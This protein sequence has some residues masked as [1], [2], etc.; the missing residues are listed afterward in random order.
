MTG[1]S[2]MQLR[3]LTCLAVLAV[4]GSVACG[5]SHGHAGTSA[6]PPGTTPPAGI[7][8]PPGP[9]GTTGASRL[10]TQGTFGPTLDGIQA[11]STQTYQQ[12]FTAQYAA[13]PSAL[14]PQL[15]QSNSDRLVPWWT[16][17]V[18][19]PDQLRQRVA[20][21]LSEILVVSSAAAVLVDN[22]QAVAAYG[23]LLLQNAFGNFRDL[24]DIVTH[25]PAMGEY[26]TYFKSD[27]PNP[28]TGSHAD[29]NYAREIMQ[30]FT[31]GLVMLNADGSQVV[32]ANG[33]PV[34]TYGLPE[35][36]NLARV[37]T[38]W[39]SNPVAPH[40]IGDE[41]A[42]QYDLDYLHPMA[43]Y[44]AHHDTD[45]KTIIGGVSIPA[46][47]TC[48]SDLKIALDTLFQHQNVGPFVGRQLIQRLVTS[49]PS[50]AY[51]GRVSAVFA[52]DGQGVRGDMFA[53]IEAILTDPE[54]RTAGT[55]AKLRE[56]VLRFTELY[57]AMAATDIAGDG[58]I[59]E[60]QV[61]TYQGYYNFAQSP[62]WAPTVF[63]FF[64]SGYSRPGPLLS[65]GLF[66]PEF[67]I[68]NENTIVLLS[69]QLEY[70]GYQ[71][72]DGSGAQHSGPDGYPVA[73]SPTTVMLHTGEWEQF[74][75]DPGTLLDNLNLVF[76][77]G[78]M[79]AA[80]KA[81]IVQ[82]VT[83]IPATSPGQRV[84]EAAFLVVTS[85]QYAVQR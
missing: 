24:L 15:P 57:R 51:L 64:T 25:S 77:A 43:P 12:W 6:N 28:A 78:Q 33:V 66:S 75:S 49:N 39:A 74:A 62:Y 13:T 36:E 83:G 69:N 85:P 72:I 29:E 50:A 46:G 2:L 31:V 54:A 48:E 70:S 11:A 71:Y 35:I 7:Q 52:N 68:T 3:V 16:V 56:P 65:A 82:Y 8:L 73:T 37:F 32:D 84:A 14:L 79:P 53:L 44:D 63:N 18:N 60:G 55:A 23:D 17:A 59:T 27:K 40:Q 38:G 80:M 41:N 47:G 21:A 5:S 42:W 76:M 22:S 1:G 58:L 10:L 81:S 9:I 19:G 20:F 61:V 30:L 34:P 45:A 26:L 67:E 4:S